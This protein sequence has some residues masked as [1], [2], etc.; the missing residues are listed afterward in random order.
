MDKELKIDKKIVEIIELF[1]DHA[2]VQEIISKKIFI[3]Y[4]WQFDSCV[5]VLYNINEE[6]S[7]VISLRGWK[8]GKEE[9]KNRR[10]RAFR[11]TGSTI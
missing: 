4:F 7:N 11:G 8:D 9:E 2:L 3:A 1:G 10:K 5:P 6:I